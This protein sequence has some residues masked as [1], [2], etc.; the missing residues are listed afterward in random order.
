[1]TSVAFGAGGR[2]TDRQAPRGSAT[3]ASP[4]A[5]E[6]PFVGRRRVTDTLEDALDQVRRCGARIVVVE[7][8][9]GIGKSRLVDRFLQRH[10]DLRVLRAAGEEWEAYVPYGLV[11]QLLGTAG[12]RGA[13]LLVTTERALP[14]Q[15]PVAVG[16]QVLRVLFE[17]AGTGPLL[18]V[19]DDAQWADLDSLRALIFVL[20]RLVLEP[21]LTLL[22]VR[23]EDVGRLPQGLVR[24]AGGPSGVHVELGGL[25]PAEIQELAAALE[26]ADFP[27]LAAQRLCDLTGGNPRD[28]TALLVELPPERWRMG[29]PVLPA[30]RMFTQAVS[31]RLNA[32]SPAARDLVEAVAVLGEDVGLADAGVLACVAEPLQ[33]LEEACAA[34]L[35]DTPDRPA[36]HW[37]GFTRPLVRAAVYTQMGPDR[38]ARLHR[39]A[40]ALVDD[41]GEALHHRAAAAEPPN[42]GLADELVALSERLRTEGASS[43]AAWALMDASRLSARRAE[44]ERWLMRAV[45]LMSDTGGIVLSSAFVR[46]VE[47]SAPGPVRDATL[48]HI[49][50]LRGRSAEADERLRAAWEQ[51]DTEQDA[52]LAAL[53]AHRRALH[54]LGRLRGGEVAE[55]ARRAVEL[56]APGDP[57]REESEGLCAL[58]EGMLGRLPEGAACPAAAART[59]RCSGAD[60]WLSLVVD[61]PAGA[62][63]ALAEVGHGSCRQGSVRIAVWSFVWLSRAGFASGAWD[64]AAADAERAVSMLEESGQEWLRPLARWAAVSVPAARGEWEAA[65]RHALAAAA[66]GGD[67]ELMVVAA[68]LARTQLAT[69]RGDHGAVLRALEPIRRI[70]PR[71]GVDEPGFWPWPGEY[72]DALVSTGRLDEAEAFLPEHEELAAAR[73]RGSALAGLARVRGRLEA[74]RGRLDAAE[75]AFQRGLAAVDGESLPFMRGMVE[76]A[77][78]QVLRRGGRRRAA[79]AQLQAARERL[80]ALGARPFVER[81]ER[82][83]SA[84]GL[85]PAK[86]STF[87]PSRLTAQEMAVARLVAA[88]MS[89][90]Q[91]AGELFVSIKTVQFHLTHVYAK[92]GIGSRGE[93]AAQLREDPAADEAADAPSCEEYRHVE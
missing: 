24:L 43:Q 44:R 1:M 59:V 45:D 21:V 41:E 61:D 28:V 50:L 63:G 26:V 36:S 20:R 76:L 62:L 65:E 19:V 4:P 51:C 12:V 13:N 33:A 91:V 10:P 35:L 14:T 78:G 16:R 8:P 80:S 34:G 39:A 27:A 7:G 48:G 29:E 56:T 90:R 22:L 87:D 2:H 92:L 53:V 77:H 18:L 71:E 68:G 73:G 6:E 70:R 31:R 54:A 89:N 37:V 66:Q 75:E 82:E 25:T 58:G 64:E 5:A 30:P 15:E 72:G 40:A 46:D 79:S 84:C 49:A 52:S 32:C 42:A 88:G 81:C 74:A 38:R 93:L 17:L 3:G 55:W 57:V 85:A 67:Y 83:L 47:E 60:G 9:A 86:R 11:D 69:A 23:S